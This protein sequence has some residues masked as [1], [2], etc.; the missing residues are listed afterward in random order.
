MGPKQ[1]GKNAKHTEV[2]QGE[3]QEEGAA[4]GLPVPGQLPEVSH[5]EDMTSVSA[6]LQQCLKF[7]RELTEP[8]NKEVI[9]DMRWSQLHIQV[10]NLREDFEQQPREGPQSLSAPHSEEPALQSPP[11]NEVTGMGWSQSAVPRLEESDDIEQYLTTFER[12]AAAYQ[13]PEGDWAVRLV[14]HLTGKARSAYVSMAAGDTLT[15]RRVKEAIL[16]KYEINQEVYRQRFRD[17]DIR[18]GETP[19]ELYHRLRDLYHKWIRP[20]E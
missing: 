11:W 14:P 8:W 5:D 3:S 20:G 4:G 18:Q 17:P 10:N 9:K 6:M 19:C 15:Y 13:W 16:T 12:L 7:Q 1:A 2:P